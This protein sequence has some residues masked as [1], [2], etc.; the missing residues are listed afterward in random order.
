MNLKKLLSSY[1]RARP[2]LSPAHEK[3]Y[4]EQYKINR[5][6]ATAVDSAAQKLEQWMHRKVAMAQG[7]PILELGAGTL[8]H[9]KFEIATEPY[10]IVEP[11]SSLYDGKPEAARIRAKYNSVQE[12]PENNRYHRIFSIA[13]LEHL[14][15]LPADVARSAIL[16]EDGGVF[17]A[18]IPS[19]GGFLWW[20]GW[21][22]STGLGFYLRTGLDYGVV[23]RHEHVNNAQEIIAVVT[24]FFENVTVA[25]FP[26]PISQLSFY[27]YI[28][29]QRPRRTIAQEFLDRSEGQVA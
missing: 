3:I 10:D 11:F 21:R 15:N 6:G 16:L 26:T 22:L 24:H 9:L 25:R 27:S 12:V 5:E 2:P 19:E 23:M 14:T 7:G 18:G 28:E 20:L 1:P 8:N 13:V 4:A 29:A 17:Q